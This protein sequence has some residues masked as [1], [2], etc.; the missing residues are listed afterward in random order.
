[1]ENGEVVSVEV[2]GVIYASPDQIP[3]P[4]DREKILQ[5]MSRTAEDD[6][7]AE[8]EKE[9][10]DFDKEFEELEK[11]R[12]IYQSSWDF[13][14]CRRDH[15]YRSH[16][17]HRQPCGLPNKRTG[18]V[19]DM[20]IQIQGGYDS[21]TYQAPRITPIGCQSPY[22]MGAQ[23][24]QLSEEADINLWWGAG[25]SF[26][27]QASPSTPTIHPAACDV[28]PSRHHGQSAWFDRLRVH[29]VVFRPSPQEANP[30]LAKWLNSSP[31]GTDLTEGTYRC[32]FIHPYLLAC[33]SSTPVINLLGCQASGSSW[34]LASSTGETA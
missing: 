20:T 22:P 26:T 27:T 2:D 12:Q 29:L 24:V 8:F 5:L 3:D 33:C 17:R 9:F 11:S 19:V 18:L 23:V 10:K 16:I 34:R 28:A 14:I 6:F 31:V 32:G 13:L 1:M 15:G 21:G 7:D 25:P 30:V 4:E